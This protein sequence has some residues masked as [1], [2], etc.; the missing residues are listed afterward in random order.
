MRLYREAEAA[1]LKAAWQ[2]IGG[3]YESG[4][5]VVADANEAE[6]GIAAPPT[7]ATSTPIPG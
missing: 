1:G 3:L 5:G 6:S 7:S 2:N 4:T